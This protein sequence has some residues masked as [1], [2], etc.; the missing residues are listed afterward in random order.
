[1]AAVPCL[2]VT[3]RMSGLLLLSPPLSSL[4]VPA[5][6]RAALVLGLS[7][8]MWP[9]QTVPMPDV[10]WA[11]L[12]AW[13]VMEVVN[14]AF[15]ALGVNI[16][17]AA[18]GLGARL[19]DVQ[20]G[21]GIGQVLDPSSRRLMPV[22]SAAFTVLA[23]VI[24]LSVDAHH[25]VLRA[26]AMGLE[27]FPVGQPWPADAG[28]SVLVHSVKGLFTLGLA[29]V[30]PVVFC[31]VLIE[32][33]LGVVARSLPQMNVFVVGIPIKL[34][35]GLAALASWMAAA[36]APMSKVFD[37]TFRSWESFLT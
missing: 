16:G 25:L 34:L 22:L 5:L 11:M 37:V 15:M 20:I 2:L 29:L 21:F 7:A 35:A 28:L 13:S 33:A 26:A 19:L 3:L 10:G 30:A 23:P 31:L 32:L 8:A 17:F 24:F 18:A 6:A 1:M 12:L 9:L 36:T 4:A 14:G 27:R